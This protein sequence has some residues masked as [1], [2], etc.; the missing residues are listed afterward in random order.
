VIAL[1]LA[2]L[3][4][5]DI[6]KEST[7]ELEAKATIVVRTVTGRVRLRGT[8]KAVA[9]VR[10]VKRGRDRELVEIRVEAGKDTLTIETKYPDRRGSIEVEI[11]IDVDVPKTAKSLAIEV[12]SGS[13]EV[14]DAAGESKFTT[15]SGPLSVDGLQGSLTATT[16]SG[17]IRI[18]KLSGAKAFVSLTSGSLEGAGEV[19]DL[20]IKSVSGRVSFDLTPKGPAWSAKASC[21]SGGVVLRLPESAGAKVELKTMSGTL[22]SDFEL[23]DERRSGR[24]SVDRSL[25]GTVGDGAGTIRATTIS[26][27]VKLGKLK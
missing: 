1:L 14:K 17:E 2:L 16:I 22:A 27:D 25:R 4:Q 9:Q 20:E 21:I 8:D 18:A 6:V 11:E 19:G 5:D 24:D 7:H 3:L 12:V 15:V 23:K 10:T 26:G 13:I